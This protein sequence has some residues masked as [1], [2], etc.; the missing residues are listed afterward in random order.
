MMEK[1]EEDDADDKGATL[2]GQKTIAVK[3][4]PTWTSGGPLISEGHHDV[5][6][7]KFT[8]FRTLGKA[9]TLGDTS[10]SKRAGKVPLDHRPNS[11]ESG[12]SRGAAPTR[13]RVGQLKMDLPP[14]FIFSQQ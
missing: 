14:I 12:I 11:P 6:P 3:A 9:S 5:S 2:L 8:S 10:A 7:P 4:F 13:L 1:D